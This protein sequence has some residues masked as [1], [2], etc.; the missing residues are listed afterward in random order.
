M[1]LPTKYPT[2]TNKGNDQ[3]QFPNEALQQY[4]TTAT[5]EYNSLRCSSESI[6][7]P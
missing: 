7:F 2:G 3:Q 1:K 6:K 4:V 5:N